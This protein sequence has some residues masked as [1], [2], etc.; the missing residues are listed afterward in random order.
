M[1]VI[2]RRARTGLLVCVAALCA[3]GA[4]GMAGATSATLDWKDSWRFVQSD[5]AVQ[6]RMAKVREQGPH[7][8]VR[9]QYRVNDADEVYTPASNGYHL[10]RI[11]DDGT[12]YR[13]EFPPSF[14]G[15]GK[16][17]ELPIEVAV[18]VDGSEVEWDPATNDR[19]YN[20]PVYEPNGYGSCVDDNSSDS[21]C[22][23]YYGF[24][25]SEVS[26]EHQYVAE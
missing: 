14:R 7:H 10:Y 21:R 22:E 13:V 4:I 15:T 16:V 17:Y 9:M 3:P 6:Y 24:D 8:I 1:A 20:N 26:A 23:G 2:G 19:I 18:F 25:R 5:K 11:A 12:R